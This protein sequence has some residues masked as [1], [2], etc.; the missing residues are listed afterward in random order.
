MARARQQ[1]ESDDRPFITE[2]LDD[3]HEPQPVPEGEYDVRIVKATQGKSKKGNDMISLFLAIDGED[4]SGFG[5]WLLGW[6]GD[7]DEDQVKSRKLEMKRFV[8]AF[9]VPVDFTASDLVGQTASVFLMQEEGDDGVVR[10]RMRL[11]KLKE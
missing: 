4:A 3:V 1:A 5:H 7:T 8:A 9:D 10:N 2:A 6:D 11:P